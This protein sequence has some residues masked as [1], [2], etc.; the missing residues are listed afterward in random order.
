[1]GRFAYSNRGIIEETPVLSIDDLKSWGYLEIGYR[2][3]EIILST[4]G[5]ETARMRIIVN[6]TEPVEWSSYIQFDYELNGEM[7]H[8]RHEIELFPCSY[9]NRFY[10]GCGNC[11]KRIT[12]LY[13]C[14]GYCSCRHCLGLVYMVSRKH[15][16]K[17]EKL[18]RSRYLRYKAEKLRK[19]RHPRKANR[20]LFKAYWLEQQAFRNMMHILENKSRL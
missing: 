15:R 17:F 4:N 5:N 2:T 6:I 14:G 3:G 19:R 16:D 8:D 10:F 7:V 13:F 18:D 1:M 12:A 9:G 11:G 20:L